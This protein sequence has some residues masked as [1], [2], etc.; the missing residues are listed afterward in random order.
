[1]RRPVA[2]IDAGG[3]FLERIG[4]QVIQH[5]YTQLG[6]LTLPDA[7]RRFGIHLGVLLHERDL[8]ITVTERHQITV[9]APVH[10]LVA[11][12]LFRSPLK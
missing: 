4:A 3:G 11:G 6:E 10:R 2:I 8:P 5:W 12:R 7:Q 9:V 1:M